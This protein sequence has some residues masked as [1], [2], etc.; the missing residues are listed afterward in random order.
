[1]LQE[2]I[3]VTFETACCT[4]ICVVFGVVIAGH[5]TVELLDQDTVLAGVVST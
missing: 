1:M 3:H 4:S 2:I 5:E